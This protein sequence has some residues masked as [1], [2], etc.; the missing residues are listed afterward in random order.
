MTDNREPSADD[1]PAHRYWDDATFR[2]KLI[3]LIALAAIWFYVLVSGFPVSLLRAGI[4]GSVFLA[5]V[6]RG[7][8][9]SIPSA[10]FVKVLRL[11]LAGLGYLAISNELNRLGVATSRGSVERLVKGLPPY[12]DA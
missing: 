3:L 9:R 12:N 2:T 5:V 4:M 10:L 6:A 1:A 8:P 7:R 11:K